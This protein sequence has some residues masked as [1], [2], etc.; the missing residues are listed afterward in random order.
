MINL[1]EETIV[2]MLAKKIMKNC[3]NR[4]KQ[5]VVCKL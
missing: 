1:K 4:S 5:R 3:R 2:F